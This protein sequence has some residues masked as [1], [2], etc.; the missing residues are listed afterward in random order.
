MVKLVK[1]YWFLI[2]MGAVIAAL[3]LLSLSHSKAEAKAP[4]V[5]YCHY[6]EGKH[7][8]S[9]T[10]EHAGDFEFT[11][12]AACADFKGDA[13]KDCEANWCAN[14]QP[15]DQCSNI[16][17]KQSEIPQG[18]ERGE[19]NTCVPVP[20]PPTCPDNASLNSDE[21]C[22]CN[23]GY[24]AADS[25]ELSCVPDTNPTPTPTT[26]PPSGGPGNPP[27]FAGSSTEAPQCG[28]A[29]VPQLPANVHVYRKGDQAV[30][31]WF[32]T[33]GDQVHIYY[34]Q[35]ASPDWQYSLTQANTGYAV[36]NGLGTLDITFTVQQVNGC[37]GGASATASPVV[38][39]ATSGWVLFR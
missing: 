24:H 20:T 10:D 16:A 3:G 9:L 1:D 19:G 5:K 6:D 13:K 15:G 35:V 32:P 28:I 27:T 4:D 12:T 31:K 2:L 23:T 7:V 11:G 36:I 18:Y 38:D 22:V 39:G 29:S 25:E 14:N 33:G 17:G 37:S 34:K 8:W 21:H 30:V 26:A